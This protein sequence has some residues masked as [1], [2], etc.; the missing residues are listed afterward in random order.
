[1]PAVTIDRKAF[2][3]DF[4]N[5]DQHPDPCADPCCPEHGCDGTREECA[6]RKAEPPW[7]WG[8]EQPWLWSSREPQ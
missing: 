3:D 1:M 7:N 5:D 8:D 6:C 2:W 4:F